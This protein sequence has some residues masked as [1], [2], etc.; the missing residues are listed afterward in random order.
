[1]ASWSEIET[2]APELARAARGRFEAHTHHTIATLRRDGSPRISGIECKFA[3]GEL[4]V[5]S[6]W[7]AVKALDLRRDPRF[8]LHS[9][10]EDP[11]DW[12]GDARVS[13]VAEEVTDPE[14]WREIYGEPPSGR[15][16]L[17]RLDLHEVVLVGLSP[18]RAKLVIES[19]RPGRGL[20][21]VER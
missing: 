15:S 8:S 16:H 5:G 19:F 11:P 12:D 2:A 7:K 18:D 21:R 6:M 20:R 17:F 9:H 10:S 1:M 3:A 4:F 14:R 13:G